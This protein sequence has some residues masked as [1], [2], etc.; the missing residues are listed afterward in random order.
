M[1][2]LDA[3]NFDKLPA[4]LNLA[5]LGWWKADFDRRVYVCSDFLIDLLNLKGDTISF[6]EFRM[7][8]RE[9]YR[10]RITN[11]FASILYQD[12]YEQIFPVKTRYGNLWVHSKLGL[13]ERDEEG[14]LVAW[15]FL[16]CIDD[17]EEK[18]QIQQNVN[19]LLYQQNSISRSLFSFLKTDDPTGVID[20]ILYEILRQAGGSRVYI[21]EYDY[22][23]QIQKCTYEAVAEGV[24][25]QKNQLSRLPMKATPWWTQ[26]L[27]HG[28]PIILFSLNEL[29]E[30]AINEKEILGGQDITSLMVVPLLSKDRVWGY[31]GIDM[32]GQ[33]K[34]WTNE[35]YQWFSALAN[36]ISICLELH[37]SQNIV[38]TEREYYKNLYEH[39][40]LAYL[41]IKLIEDEAGRITDYRFVELN[42]AFEKV[43]GHPISR[44]AGK[45]ASETLRAD[46]QEQLASIAELRIRKSGEVNFSTFDGKRYFHTVMYFP[47][48][49]EMVALFSDMTEITRTHQ[50]LEKSEKTLRNL[51]KNIPVGIEIYDKDGVLLDMNDRDAEIFGIRHKTSALGVNFFDNPNV[52]VDVK[53]QVREQK[54]VDF[55]IQYDFTHV[56]N[57]YRT[58]AEGI[59]NLIVK[60]T[61]LYNSENEL[62]NYLLIL[63]DNTETSTAYRKI[64]E[65]EDFFSVIADFAKIGYFKWN[66]IAKTGFAMSQWYQN[67]N[68]D[69]NA[70][71][72]EVVGN[73]KH[74]HPD[75][76]PRIRKFYENIHTGEVR[77]MK[78]EVRVREKDGGWKWLRC[79]VAC[80]EFDPEHGNIEVIGV[81]LDI[82][83]L[84]ETE[85]KL[86]DAKNK[87]ETLDRLK[88]A[89]LANMSHEIRTPLNA[90]VG[91]SSLLAETD[92]LEE[93]EQCIHII[94]ENN[95][96]LLQLISDIL[97]LSKIEAGTFDMTYGEVDVNLLCKEMVRAMKMKA[98]EGVDLRF[99]SHLSE[100]RITNDRN[101]LT[102][103]LNNF[104][105]NA[106]KFTKQGYIEVGYEVKD[107]YIEF[108]VSDTGIGIPCEQLNSVFDRFVKLNSFVHG[109]GLGLSICKSIVEQM[110]GKIGVDSE[111][112]K[113]SCFWFSI[114]YQNQHDCPPEAERELSEKI[115]VTEKKTTRPV[116][117]IAEDTES[118]YILLAAVLKKEYTLLWAHNGQEAVDMF[119]S[120]KPDLILMDIKMPVMDGLTA[121][122]L[123]RQEDRGIPIIALTAFAF[124]SDRAKAIDA[125]CDEYMSKPI[126]MQQLKETMRKLLEGEVR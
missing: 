102:Q 75:D 54:S 46:L 19:N 80:K 101:R 106:L 85:I 55:E 84:K 109:T 6:E 96:L 5:R 60:I 11:E 15:G 23:E 63:I 70:P 88:S 108:Y 1:N 37:R 115:H 39:M 83:E 47:Q 28:K 67:W 89:F 117:L 123:I 68:E 126:P 51:Y 43:T 7:I 21:F 58:E 107:G 124:D 76:L 91:F 49:D 100:C 25:P 122:R 64:Q 97:D 18:S 125:G 121:T 24:S 78:E 82:T 90:I 94:R 111:V 92:E 81:N 44:Y 72:A 116:I 17:L 36:I 118:N 103:L 52:P 87:A 48:P 12:V 114:P 71:L 20:S 104:V 79:L 40:P 8:I 22:S 119:R 113:G 3:S 57:Y 112:G 32:V 16:Q 62:E 59:K 14:H 30:T 50:A 4:L 10:Y 74:I 110:G 35:D 99:G 66:P 93:K 33:F 86:I 2:P 27:T 53:Q 98:P 95:D 56:K 38:R 105:S 34:R 26:Q 65:F 73:Y 13:K 9:D 42:P 45:L 77:Y 61:P 69:E 31:I 29:P 41:R 120:E